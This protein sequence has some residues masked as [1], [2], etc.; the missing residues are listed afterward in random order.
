MACYPLKKALKKAEY[1]RVEYKSKNTQSRHS[2]YK[3]KPCYQYSTFGG[4]IALIHK[5][6]VV[7]MSACK[8]LHYK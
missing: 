1:F 2:Q 4:I 6:R 7:L 8:A 5:I 3:Y